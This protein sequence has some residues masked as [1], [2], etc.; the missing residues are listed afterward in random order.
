MCRGAGPWLPSFK[1]I[2]PTPPPPLFQAEDMAILVKVCIHLLLTDCP[3]CLKLLKKSLLL[4]RL[5][6]E[7]KVKLKKVKI[8]TSIP[9]F[10]VSC[11]GLVVV[12]D[13]FFILPACTRAKNNFLPIFDA[14][15]KQFF[16]T[17]IKA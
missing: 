15:Y 11:K 17:K 5:K 10:Y 8:F 2:S 12:A 3:S 1:M 16:H 9:I 14:E 4:K 13:I 7:K 6:S